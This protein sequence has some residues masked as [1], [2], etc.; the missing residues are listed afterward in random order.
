MQRLLG[1][2]VDGIITDR[3]DVAVEVVR[4]V[5][6]GSS[7]G[8]RIYFFVS[9]AA[10]VNFGSMSTGTSVSRSSTFCTSGRTTPSRSISVLGLRV[11]ALRLQRHDLARQRGHG[12]A[13]LRRVDRE[14]AVGRTLKAPASRK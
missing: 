4:G 6:R 13:D 14:R 11:A 12:V 9:A 7:R 2:G 8:E 1:W 10:V 3:P 5:S